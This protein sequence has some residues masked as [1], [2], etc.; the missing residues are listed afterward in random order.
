MTP[1]PS[2]A[3]MIITPSDDVSIRASHPEQNFGS[4]PIIEVDSSSV[5]EMLLRFE[6]PE[7]GTASIKSA[8]IRLYTINGSLMGG[9]FFVVTDQT[10]QEETIT[11]TNAPIA[12][13]DY[14]GSLGRVDENVWY[15]LIVT[16]FVSD[17]TTFSIRGKSTLPDGADSS[18]KEDLA[19]F[20]P[21]LVIE[22]TP[23]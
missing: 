19:G 1:P 9:D 13:G 4:E 10:W 5:K 18:S 6:L 16:P 12:D 17:T 11:W 23:E 3:K 8:K 22:F 20:T 21:E 15:E 14:I 2:A 7:W